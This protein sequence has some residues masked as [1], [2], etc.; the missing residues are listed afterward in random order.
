MHALP[1]ITVCAFLA[2][3]APL[4]GGCAWDTPDGRVH[5]VLGLGLVRTSSEAAPTS[6]DPD[7]PVAHIDRASAGGVLIGSPVPGGLLIGA[8]TLERTSIP[9]GAEL[10]VCVPA[11]ISQR[12]TLAPAPDGAPQ[13]AIP[14]AP[15]DP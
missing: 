3:L 10:V 1:Q 14:H 11:D 5:L 13:E 4:A 9:T 2:A 15:P 6:T 7:G 12:V 8:L